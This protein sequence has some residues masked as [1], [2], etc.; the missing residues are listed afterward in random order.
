MTSSFTSGYILKIEAQYEDDA[1]E[2]M[3]QPNTLQ[4]TAQNDGKFL[5]VLVVSTTRAFSTICKGC[6]GPLAEPILL[7]KTLLWRCFSRR[8]QAAT[9]CNC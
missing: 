7:G 3:E 2:E 8:K 6:K 9:Y 1:V 4:G 5:Q